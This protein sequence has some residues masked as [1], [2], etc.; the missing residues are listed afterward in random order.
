[1]TGRFPTPGFKSINPNWPFMADSDYSD[2]SRAPGITSGFYRF[3]N[4]HHG[5]FISAVVTVNLLCC[6]LH[7]NVLINMEVL[8]YDIR[9]VLH[10]K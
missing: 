5:T 6:I 3:M 1:M 7:F 10:K 9:V 4:V 8:L 2:S